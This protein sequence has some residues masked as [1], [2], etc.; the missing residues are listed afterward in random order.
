MHFAGNVFSFLYVYNTFKFFVIVILHLC[1]AQHSGAQVGFVAQWYNV[2][3]S[4]ANFP[5]PT[6]DLQ[7]AD[8]H[9]GKPSA[10]GQSTRPTQPFILS[11][12]I[13]Q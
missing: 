3:L 8:E 6:L 13:N 11:G 7:L 4:P 2:G 12:S 10:A 5:C 1:L 9:V